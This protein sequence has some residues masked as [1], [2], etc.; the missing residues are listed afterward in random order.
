VKYIDEFR[1][2]KIANNISRAIFDKARNLGPINLM[3]VC[4]T[5]TMSICKF[6][7]RGMLPEN[8]NLIS[9]PGCPVCVT[10]KSY[11]DKAI[12]ISTLP[13]VVL[14]TFGD[15]MRVPG[16]RS[17]LEKEKSCG[18]SIK[19]VYSVLDAVEMAEKN[20]D[21]KIVFLGIGFETTSPTVAASLAYAKKK[22]LKNFFVYS[23]HKIIPPAMEILAKDPAVAIDGF[24]CPAH[25]SAII[26][27]GPY[28]IIAGK[29]R[30]PCV[31]A[32][33]EPLDVLQG[34]LMLIEQIGSNSSYVENQYKRVVKSSGN[35][36]ATALLD[37]VFSVEDSEW[38]GIGRLAKSG[39]RLSR[40]YSRF[41]ALKAF[42]LPEVKTTPDK[43]C[44][45][46]SVLKGIKTPIECKLF[47]KKC[48]PQ[49]PQ[50]ACMV[51]SEGACAA[52]H[53]YRR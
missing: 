21:K 12:A 13:D 14:T 26:G 20:S 50:G 29:Y 16:S 19:V 22:N 52:Y 48:T 4:G 38:R 51:S 23:G 37:K 24:L 8:I 32:G 36:K 27:T 17:S 47:S 10:P 6:G 45:C 2:N 39:L 18:R 3:E 34:I 11:L 5:H 33:F 53:R 41:D 49:D 44:I 28:K 46:G 25:V 30:I 43:G 42:S 31:I 1:D 40:D 9:G 35:K 15:M 7:I